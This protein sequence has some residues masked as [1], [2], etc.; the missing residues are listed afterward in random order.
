MSLWHLQGLQEDP[1]LSRLTPDQALLRARL[2]GNLGRRHCSRWP[3]LRPLQRFH[4]DLHYYDDHHYCDD[5]YCDD[6]YDH[7]GPE[8]HLRPDRRHHG[9]RRDL[10]QH[11]DHPE[12]RGHQR[13]ERQKV[14]LQECARLPR[15]RGLRLA[16]VL[17]QREGRDEL[18]LPGQ[19]SVRQHEPGHRRHRAG[20]DHGVASG[21]P[22]GGPQWP[23]G[24]DRLHQHGPVPARRRIRDHRDARLLPLSPERAGREEPE[25]DDVRLQEVLLRGRVGQPDLRRP[26]HPGGG[27]RRGH[28]LGVYLDHHHHDH[29]LDQH[30]GHDHDHDLPL[31]RHLRRR[32]LPRPEGRPLRPR[33]L[34]PAD[35]R[36]PLRHA[37]TGAHEHVPEDGCRRSSGR[38]G[39]LRHGLRHP[40][41]RGHGGLERAGDLPRTPAF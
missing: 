16:S 14:H 25:P 13:R 6:H 12:R 40:M 22:P 38:P 3:N 5:H 34:L 20:G 35:L 15:E 18:A 32:P 7:V 11:P 36:I 29:D 1:Q 4:Q 19:Q 2:R 33:E 28:E 27:L 8:L 39:S 24:P 21:H 10:G 37:G 31:H 23:V 17:G 30:D 9:R 41:R 26:R